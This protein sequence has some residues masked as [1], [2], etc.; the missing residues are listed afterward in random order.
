MHKLIGTGAACSSSCSAGEC[1]GGRG[2]D[3]PLGKYMSTAIHQQGARDVGYGLL[4]W[5]SRDSV[6]KSLRK[7]NVETAIIP[8]GCTSVLDVSINKPFKGWQ[9]AS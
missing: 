4:P 5:T 6:K 3:A 8:G 9:R 1:L 2:V 7:A